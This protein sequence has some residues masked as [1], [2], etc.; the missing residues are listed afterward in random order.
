MQEEIQNQEQEV[1]PQTE[2]PKLKSIFKILAMV[3][4]VIVIII[5]IILFKKG[6]SLSKQYNQVFSIKNYEY[7]LSMKPLSARAGDRKK[8]EGGYRYIDVYENTDVIREIDGINFKNSIILKS[9]GHPDSFEF[10]I[11]NFYDFDL[12]KDQSGNLHFYE[13]GF[14]GQVLK[15]IFSI[16][17]SDNAEII[18]DS[19]KVKLVLNEELGEYP[20][21]VAVEIMKDVLNIYSKPHLSGDWMVVFETFGKS[22]LEILNNNKE[23]KFISLSCG[24]EEK[25]V[26]VLE[27]GGYYKNWE[28]EGEGKAV[29]NIIKKG[30]YSLEFKFNDQIRVAR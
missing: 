27:E 13:L 25:K 19:D 28:C 16:L 30:D 6:D 7:G 24:D 12:A 29:F 3:L 11:D 23:V 26:K 17:K 21:E 10:N 9:E 8:E 22:D 14:K 4:I 20:V 1:Q 18:I 15:R 2:Q 5:V